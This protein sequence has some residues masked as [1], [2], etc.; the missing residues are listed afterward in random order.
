M[1][2][3]ALLFFVLV[4]DNLGN[5]SSAPNHAAGSSGAPNQTAESSDAGSSGAHGAPSAAAGSPGA[6][7]ANEQSSSA[8]GESAGHEHTEYD[9]PD[10][11][12]RH[13]AEKVSKEYT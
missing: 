4:S 3:F 2:N 10:I 11:Q 13:L 7:S 5:S 6:L 1:V 8:E 12:N 9:I